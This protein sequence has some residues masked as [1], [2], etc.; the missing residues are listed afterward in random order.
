MPW[1]YMFDMSQRFSHLQCN[2]RVFLE[3][4]NLKK[5]TAKVDKRTV[6]LVT[7]CYTETTP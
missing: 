1:G 7:M 4:F 2:T 6:N 3:N 5:G